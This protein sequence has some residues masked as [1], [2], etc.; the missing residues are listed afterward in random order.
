[1]PP[2]SLARPALLARR[3]RQ[4]R[5]PRRY[6]SYE[7]GADGMLMLKDKSFVEF[8]HLGISPFKWSPS[9]GYGFRFRDQSLWP[10]IVYTKSAGFPAVPVASMRK[11][12]SYLPGIKAWE[13]RNLSDRPE[14]RNI[15]HLTRTMSNTGVVK[16]RNCEIQNARQVNVGAR[17]FLCFLWQDFWMKSSSNCT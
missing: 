17:A 16:A 10:N 1:M 15:I 2:A 6:Q 8:F 9:F 13:V 3:R 12:S 5:R 11:E 4:R 14:A 7:L